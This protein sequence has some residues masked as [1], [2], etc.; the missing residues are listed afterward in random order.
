MTGENQGMKRF[1]PLYAP[2]AQL[3]EQLTLNQWALGSSP[4]WCTKMKDLRTVSFAGL[5]LRCVR[6]KGLRMV[7]HPLRGGL[8]L[9]RGA[10]CIRLAG[11]GR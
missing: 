2:L 9:R 7:H 6:R 5:F 11:T 8:V 3:V 10:A 1:E 4:R